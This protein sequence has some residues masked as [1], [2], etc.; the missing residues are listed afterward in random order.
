MSEVDIDQL[1]EKARTGS[2]DAVERLIGAYERKVYTLCL[3]LTAN[4][5][6]AQDLAQE[7]FLRLFQSLHTFR[8]G[9]A[10]DTWL[11]RVT[12]NL[13]KDELRRRN[14]HRGMVSLDAPLSTEKDEVQRQVLSSA[15]DPAADLEQRAEAEAVWVA[16]SG[17]PQ[18]Y[19]II[20]VLRE[21]QGH[22]YEEL[23]RILGCSIGTVKSRLN[24]AR[25]LLG[26]ALK[27]QDFEHGI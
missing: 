7:V 12:V 2:R 27:S 18:D 14:R 22:S 24:R 13:W 8:G 11:H 9:S 25:R 21:M 4:P 16:L 20:L 15:L 3:R 23:A 19:R 26:D 5:D 17:L 1:I 6:D 10:F